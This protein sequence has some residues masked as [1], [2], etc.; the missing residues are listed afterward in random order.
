V[1]ALKHLDSLLE[2]LFAWEG[3]LAKTRA[4]LLGAALLLTA[5]GIA[6]VHSTTA[7]TIAGEPES[8]PS[9]SALDQMK[10]AGVGLAAM[11]LVIAIDY[12]LIE[13]AS[14]LVY[15]TIVGVLGFVLVGKRISG[16]DLERWVQ[17][18]FLNV[19]PSEV[20]KIALILALARYL[21]FR[22]DMRSLSGL[23]MPIA[24]TLVPFILVAAQPNLGTA[25]ML[26]PILL[27]ILF[28]GGAR[29]SY[30]IGAIVVAA[31][32]F[33]AAYY[34]SIYIGKVPGID[35][36]QMIRIQL[37]LEPD[38]VSKSQ[39]GYQLAQSIISFQSGGLTGQGY[40]QGPQ[41]T[42]DHLPARQTDFIFAVIG[43]ELGFVGAAAVVLL[44]FSLVLLCLLVALYTREPFGRL[45]A[46]AVAVG[47]VAQGVQ[48]MGMTLCLTPITG[49]PLPFVSFGGS[50]LVASFIAVGL[51]LNIAFRQVRVVA[52]QDLNPLEEERVM[53]V[54]DDHPAGATRFP[55]R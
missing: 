41:N 31:L 40:H 44:F 48:N 8:F 18:G 28:L 25:L 13:R 52:S 19:Q 47:F 16:E 2:F 33:P 49:V 50:S 12:R 23:A 35:P 36:Y 22:S 15:V 17:I 21:K 24:I 20:M 1:I 3:R 54:I 39:E 43:E 26:P 38:S 5:I 42:L 10:K 53:V 46:V 32:V 9:A 11:L 27:A 14:Y 45:V 51:V 7:D 37:Y 55:G 30:L 29:R 6:F 4:C 34:A